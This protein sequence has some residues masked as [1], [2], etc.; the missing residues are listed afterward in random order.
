MTAARC[1]GTENDVAGEFVDLA[2][3]RVRTAALQ[4]MLRRI[5]IVESIR[6]YIIPV[7]GIYDDKTRDAVMALQKEA[8][9]PVNGIYDYETYAYLKER[10]DQ[11]LFAD[12]GIYPFPSTKG[13]ILKSGDVG[14]LVSIVQIMLSSVR[15]YYDLPHVPMN[16]RF[17]MATESVVREFQRISKLS[18]SGALDG[19]TWG[20][21]AE[22]YNLSV[23]DSQ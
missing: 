14:D 6:V 7:N 4:E 22:A 19:K 15:L 3:E 21:L 16:G 23:N 12:V 11:T 8:G 5:G 13:Y 1:G 17:D 9:L 18:E 20:R 2:D 10:F